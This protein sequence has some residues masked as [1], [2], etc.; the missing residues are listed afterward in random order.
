VNLSLASRKDLIDGFETEGG[1]SLIKNLSTL[2]PRV[3]HRSQSLTLFI[4][5]GF[6]GLGSGD[7]TSN[8]AGFAGGDFGGSLSERLASAIDIVFDIV[9]FQAQM[10]SAKTMMP[11]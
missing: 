2:R 6:G 8:G 9:G 3:E 5:S 11:V 10:F 1:A 7:L 4:E